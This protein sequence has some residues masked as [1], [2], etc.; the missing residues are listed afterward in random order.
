MQGVSLSSRI[1]REC[2]QFEE[3][4]E[5]V[6]SLLDFQSR[7]GMHIAHSIEK[8]RILLSLLTVEYT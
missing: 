7:G 4:P 3:F 5:S 8:L 6:T 2:H 1:S